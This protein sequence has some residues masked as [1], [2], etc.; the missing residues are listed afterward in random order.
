[1]EGGRE[2]VQLLVTSSPQNAVSTTS[3]FMSGLL[4]LPT[5]YAMAGSLAGFVHRVGQIV[6]TMEELQVVSIERCMATLRA[7]NDIFA[8]QVA[9]AQVASET[10]KAVTLDRIALDNLTVT[11][12]AEKV[13]QL[14]SSD[15]Y[16]RRHCTPM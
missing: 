7:L 6:E 9:S 16:G 3:G 13:R 10:K 2:K 1:M 14:T 8:A 5:R 12:P 15:A 11:N 4:S